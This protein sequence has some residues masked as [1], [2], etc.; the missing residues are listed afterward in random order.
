MGKKILAIDDDEDILALLGIILSDEG[1]ELVLMNTGT[2]ADQVRILHP[3]LILLDV[4]IS[5]F[6]KSGID[7]CSELKAMLDLSE[8]PVVLLSAEQELGNLAIVCGADAFVNKPFDIDDLVV[9]IKE[10]L[11]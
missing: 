5:G 10:F 6:P 7:I 4:R 8:I 1:Y 11:I 3:D 9:K 2:T